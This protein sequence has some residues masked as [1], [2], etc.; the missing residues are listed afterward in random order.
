M[1]NLSTKSRRHFL[2]QSIGAAASLA[3]ASFLSEHAP[4][5]STDSKPL[6][7]II[8]VHTHVSSSAVGG[9]LSVEQLLGWMDQREVEQAVVMPLVSPEGWNFPIST[10][11]VLDQTRDHRKRLIPF[12]A[13]D[14]R[15]R[16]GETQIRALIKQYVKLGARGFGEH[17]CG[18][19]IDD[20][21][22]LRLFKVAGEFG[23]PVLFHLDDTCN[24]DKPG[25]PGLEKVLQALPKT[26]FIGHAQGWWASISGDVKANQMGIY[27]RGPVAPGGAL[28]R[29][30][31]KYPNIYGDIS[32]GSGANAFRRDMKFGREFF[33]RHADRLLFGSDYLKDGQGIP[34][35][36]LLR[37]M[38]LPADVEAKIRRTNAEKLLG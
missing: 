10:D 35:F 29:L 12:C 36:G 3:A 2:K 15:A 16:L 4:A 25:L 21:R 32:A 1:Q 20:P 34:Q 17:K 19:A 28:D 18:V 14:P 38:K 22:S 9:G 13:I 30:L 31:E 23:L 24:T 37:D 8:D 6:P 26:T 27:P 7:K 11:W 33:I 5:E